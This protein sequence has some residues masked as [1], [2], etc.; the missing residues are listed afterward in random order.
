MRYGPPHRPA[1]EK[2]IAQLKKNHVAMGQNQKLVITL[3][4]PSIRPTDGGS[5]RDVSNGEDHPM[6]AG[7]FRT[8]ILTSTASMSVKTPTSTKEYLQPIRLLSRARGVAAA[9]DPI[10][11]IAMRIPVIMANSFFLN[12]SA[13]IFMVGTK[14]MATPNPTR[15]RPRIAQDT[16]G[17]IPRIIAPIK[18]IQ[19][20]TEMVFRGPHESESRPAGSCTAA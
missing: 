4:N 6:S 16:E 13:R 14:S 18:A 15:V 17:A 11:P 19:K 1:K 12:H 8:N 2:K 5:D 10:P 9:R 20:K 7:R 3:R